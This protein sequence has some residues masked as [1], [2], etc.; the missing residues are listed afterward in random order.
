MPPRRVWW[1]RGC[2]RS[3]EGPP[4]RYN[5][6]DQ[7][8]L[9]GGRLMPKVSPEYERTQKTR[10]IE[11]AAK[12]FAEYGYRQTTIDQVVRSLGISKGAIYIYFKNKEEL[13]ISTLDYIYEKRYSLLSGAYVKTDSLATR[14]QKLWDRIESLA[15]SDDFYI[16][17]R[18]SV[19]GFLESDR[20]PGVQLVKE[21]SYKRIYAL[22]YDLLI[23]SQAMEQ[24]SSE[25]DVSNEIIV[26]MAT[27]DGLA[28]H[29]LVGGRKL[30]MKEIQKAVFEMFPTIRDGQREE[31]DDEHGK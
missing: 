22:L 3:A 12:V 7:S 1:T 4:L 20:I 2:R 25:L 27:F 18:L 17:T 30:G 5:K 6:T 15:G 10:I 16:F 28:M 14:F 24:S 11:G 29:S 9:L 23:K 21:N 13:F 26:M 8:V 19:E 31:N